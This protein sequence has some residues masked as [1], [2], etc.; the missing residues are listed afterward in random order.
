MSAMSRSW[1][2]ISNSGAKRTT[3]VSIWQNVSD[4]P[5]IHRWVS[6]PSFTCCERTGYRRIASA[7]VPARVGKRSS[8][9][10]NRRLSLRPIL[11][12]IWKS[13]LKAKFMLPRWTLRIVVL[14]A[15][16]TSSCC[17]SGRSRSPTTARIIP[18]ETS[19][20][21]DA[22][23]NGSTSPQGVGSL[24]GRFLRYSI[25][26]AVSKCCKSRLS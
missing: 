13:G 22:T 14:P 24:A 21:I 20:S 3:S 4:L 11:P 5:A 18:P 23:R 8:I 17:W 16:Q 7:R 1:E 6:T 25:S 12:V 9:R 2:R 19:I 15:S 26:N 10:L